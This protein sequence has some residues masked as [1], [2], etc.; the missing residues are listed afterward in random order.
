MLTMYLDMSLVFIVAACKK[1][2]TAF[3]IA[4]NHNKLSHISQCCICRCTCSSDWPALRSVCT[5]QIFSV[6]WLLD[7]VVDGQSTCCT[8]GNELKFE[9]EI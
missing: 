4:E 1:Y 6:I 2:L 5:A 7:V 3:A 9:S 8:G